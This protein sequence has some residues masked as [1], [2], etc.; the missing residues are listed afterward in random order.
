[1]TEHLF[2]QCKTE[3]RSGRMNYFPAYH[4]IFLKKEEPIKDYPFG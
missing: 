2:I 3:I 4:F 1:M